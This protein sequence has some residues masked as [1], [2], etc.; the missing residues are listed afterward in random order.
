MGQCG[1]Y[2][3]KKSPRDWRGDH[4]DR[5][6]RQIPFS[7]I[8]RSFTTP[9]KQGMSP[10][11]DKAGAPAVAYSRQ[12]LMSQRNP[13]QWPTVRFS[14]PVNPKDSQL[15]LR[16]YTPIIQLRCEHWAYGVS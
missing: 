2:L 8:P 1:E 12:P 6:A 4:A 11:C 13:S 14:R 7:A 5:F 3:A 10:L 9:R 16:V 15:T